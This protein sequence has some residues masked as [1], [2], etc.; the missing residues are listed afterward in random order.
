MLI[1]HNSSFF[2]VYMYDI[3]NMICHIQPLH[4]EQYFIQ[5]QND[6]NL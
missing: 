2:N 3:A 1:P 4:L 6:L 5:Q